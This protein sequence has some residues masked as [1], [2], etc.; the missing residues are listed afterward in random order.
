MWEIR[1]EAKSF[2]FFWYLKRKKKKKIPHNNIQNL[3]YCSLPSFNLLLSSSPLSLSPSLNLSIFSFYKISW[4]RSVLRL[5]QLTLEQG[6]VWVFLSKFK[7][8][9]FELKRSISFLS[10][11]SL[12]DELSLG[13]RRHCS[14]PTTIY[15][16]PTNPSKI[17]N[18]KKLEEEKMKIQGSDL[19]LP[20]CLQILNDGLCDLIL[21]ILRIRIW[22]RRMLK[23]CF[24]LQ[25]FRAWRRKA[26]DVRRWILNHCRKISSLEMVHCWKERRR[27]FFSC[28]EKMITSQTEDSQTRTTN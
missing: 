18:V 25:R 8:R 1:D 7:D 3:L 4:H 10:M 13:S 9:D 26:R 6:Q 28:G 15:G 22:F 16:F 20:L 19:E 23:L 17:T 11:G 14:M 12:G 5:F 2:R 21:T 24:F 27:S